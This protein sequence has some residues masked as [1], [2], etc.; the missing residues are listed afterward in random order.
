MGYHLIESLEDYYMLHTTSA[1]DI[2]L[3]TATWCKPC[4]E[5]KAF[6][7]EAYPDLGVPL[8]IVDV[9]HPDLSDL[10]SDVQAMPTLEFYREGKLEHRVEGFTRSK[11]RELVE[12][13]IQ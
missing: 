2:V 4:K 7:H 11:V 1:R 9:E 5:L 8:L 6:L 12:E 13:W 3:Y 10:V